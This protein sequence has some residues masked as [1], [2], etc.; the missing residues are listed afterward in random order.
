MRDLNLDVA[1][2]LVA[3]SIENSG[4]ILVREMWRKQDRA[5]QRQRSLDQKIEDGRKPTH[6]PRSLD[7]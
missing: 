2:A 4:A 6:G 7:P 3:R 5:R 1:L